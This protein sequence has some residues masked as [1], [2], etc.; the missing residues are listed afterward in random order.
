M[1]L[2]APCSVAHDGLAKA[3]K[4]DRR[5]V[6]RGLFAHFAD[7]RFFQSFAKFDPAAGQCI[8]AMGRGAGAAHDQHPIVAHDRGADREVGS[9][10]IS[11][12]TVAVAH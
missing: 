9:R 8:E 5:D 6:E 1:P 3:D 11:P 4:L 2:D 7:D 10:G 12:C